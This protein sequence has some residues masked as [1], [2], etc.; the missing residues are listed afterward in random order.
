VIVRNEGV[1][2]GANICEFA[3][4]VKTRVLAITPAL[5]NF[6]FLFEKISVTDHLF[7]P[8]ISLRVES[9]GI[10]ML[11]PIFRYVAILF[12]NMVIPRPR[13]TST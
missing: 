1:I 4:F 3:M 13:L 10:S 2:I 12:R 9:A 5:S 6:N 11:Y 7:R 8:T